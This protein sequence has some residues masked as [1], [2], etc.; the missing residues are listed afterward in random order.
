[1]NGLYGKRDGMRIHKFILVFL[2][3]AT[4]GGLHRAE[5]SAIDTNLPVLTGASM[6]SGDDPSFFYRYYDSSGNIAHLSLSGLPL[7]PNSFYITS[8]FL[9]V[10][11]GLDIGTYSLAFSGPGITLSP[12]GAF[13]TNNVLYPGGS[14][15]L[16]YWGLLFTG[17]GMEINIWG[18]TPDNYSFWSHNSTGY[19]VAFDGGRL[20]GGE[21]IAVESDSKSPLTVSEPGSLL[22]LGFGLFGIL[23]FHR[24]LR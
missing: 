10:L 20:A 7:D 14:Q 22:M 6:P 3:V 11:G 19:N 8:G 15:A 18:N 9:D 21:V 23:G 1:M 16:D 4:V 2:F 24:K 17:N 5:A 12:Q 13:L